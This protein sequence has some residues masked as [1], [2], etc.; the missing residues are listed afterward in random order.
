MSTST[1]R[2]KRVLIIVQNLPVPLDRRPWQESLALREAGY[3]V[4]VICPR[5]AGGP[6]FQVLEGVR[7]HT[8]KPPPETSALLMST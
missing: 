8:Y 5:A 3:G 2:P 1:R 7:I 6:R 4:S